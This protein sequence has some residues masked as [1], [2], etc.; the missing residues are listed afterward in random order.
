MKHR[1][2]HSAVTM[3]SGGHGSNSTASSQASSYL[4]NYETVAHEPQEGDSGSAMLDA[5]I[6]S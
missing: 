1:L 3:I 6:Y 5:S 2:I 4:E